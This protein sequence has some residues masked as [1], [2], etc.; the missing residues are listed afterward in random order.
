MS[1]RALKVRSPEAV[2]SGRQQKIRSRMS[3]HINVPAETAACRAF[4]RLSGLSPSIGG[5]PKNRNPRNPQNLRNPLPKNRNPQRPRNP[6][7]SDVG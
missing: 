1:L 7:K 6:L 3:M 5:L 2:V 4:K